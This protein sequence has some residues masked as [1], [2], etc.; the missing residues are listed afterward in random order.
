MVFAATELGLGRVRGS[1]PVRWP[2]DGR[3][4]DRLALDTS[5]TY[6]YTPGYG[7]ADDLPPRRPRRPGQGSRPERV[8]DLPGCPHH[9]CQDRHT[10]RS[11]ERHPA[12]D[13]SGPTSQ[14][15][16]PPPPGRWPAPPT[17]TTRAGGPGRSAPPAATPTPGFIT[18]A[19]TSGTTGG[20]PARAAATSSRGSDPDDHPSA[21]VRQGHPP[22]RGRPAGRSRSAAT[23]PGSFVSKRWGKA[24]VM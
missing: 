17:T 3:R 10:R 1:G 20:R 5:C 15:W 14:R 8:P 19:P 11:R 13:R 18:S 6:T 4:P 2:A 22:G 7:A 12:P 23:L 21:P 9:C 16:R 24:S